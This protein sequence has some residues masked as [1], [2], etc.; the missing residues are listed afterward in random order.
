MITG[1]IDTETHS[2]LGTLQALILLGLLWWTWVSYCWLGNQ[3]LL[4]CAYFIRVAPAGEHEMQRRTDAA[5]VV[6]GRDAYTYLHFPLIGG[7]IIAA[8]DVEEA[9]A[10]VGDADPYGWFGATA[11]GC[12]LAIYLAATAGFARR[13]GLRIPWTRVVAAAL[14]LAGI[15]I[16]AVIGALPALAVC[17]LMLSIALALDSGRSRRAL[18]ESG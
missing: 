13:V 11:L 1:W 8:L 15:P 16:L 12:G 14:L 3:S 17:A 4:W 5:R 6:L 9:M 18:P 2:A 7:I 10:H